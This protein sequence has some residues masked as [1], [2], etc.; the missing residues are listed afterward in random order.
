MKGLIM[1][2]FLKLKY[3]LILLAVASCGENI[4]FT[5]V[6]QK[7]TFVTPAVNIYS[8]QFCPN[9]YVVAPKVDILFLIDNSSSTNYMNSG[10]KSAIASLIGSVSESFDYHAY[11]APLIPVAGENIQYFPLVVS[12]QQGLSTNVNIVGANGI[13]LFQN[14]A[15]GSAELGFT[16]AMNIINNNTSNNIFRK[17]VNTVV[18]VVSNGDDTDNL[19]DPSTGQI[20]ASNYTARF[21]EFKMLTEKFYTGASSIPINALRSKQLRFISVVPHTACQYGFKAGTRYKNMSQDIF[22]YNGIGNATSATPDSYN[23]CNASYTQIFNQIAASMP[24]TTIEKTYNFWPAKET[25]SSAAPDFDVS[26][27]QVVKIKDGVSQNIP[28]SSSNGFNFVSTHMVNKNIRQLPIVSSDHPAELKTGYFVEL[29]GTAKLKTPGE[30]LV[31]KIQDPQ[32]YYGYI[33]LARKP[34]VSETVVRINGQLVAQSSTN[35]WTLKCDGA[36]QDPCYTP[37]I[38]IKVI[39]PNGEPNSPGDFRSGY[40]L[41]LNGVRYSNEDIIDVD[42]KP[43]T[44]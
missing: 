40:V 2:R 12:N 36:P 10:M 42:Y 43:D 16:R 13:T 44:I 8:N 30:C 35:G 15:G 19:V 28:E 14:V 11:V 39:G 37:S 24:T 7:Q 5:T 31:V 38:N 41:Q 18:I 6:T 4:P 17:N 29:F 22:S 21:N 9:S 25:I 23:L 26:K 27:I 34:K 3:M 1:H 32:T 20:V 33:V